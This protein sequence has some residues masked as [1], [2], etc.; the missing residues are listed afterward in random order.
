LELGLVCWE[1]GD[2]AGTE[3]QNRA[4]LRIDPHQPDAL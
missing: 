1:M 4:V 2:F 3:E